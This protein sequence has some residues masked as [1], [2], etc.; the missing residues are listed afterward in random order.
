MLW[1]SLILG[2]LAILVVLLG[3]VALAA[4]EGGTP[5]AAQRELDDAY[6]AV[7]AILMR[8]EAEMED[9]TYEDE[10]DLQPTAGN[11]GSWKEWWR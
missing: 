7:D 8:A 11:L 2:V 5:A 10:D 4:W 3:V 9:A 6:D 1:F